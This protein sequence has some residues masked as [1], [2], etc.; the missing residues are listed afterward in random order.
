MYIVRETGWLS[1]RLDGSPRDW[2]A[3]PETGWQSQRLDGS[4]RD[5][6]AVPEKTIE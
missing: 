3:V 5:W 4:P 1:P 6:I 2:M